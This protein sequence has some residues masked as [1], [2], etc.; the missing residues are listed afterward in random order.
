[1]SSYT[2]V[3]FRHRW[4]NTVCTTFA[5]ETLRG[6]ESGGGTLDKEVEKGSDSKEVGDSCDKF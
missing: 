5:P 3:I 4:A 2:A 6:C 1:M